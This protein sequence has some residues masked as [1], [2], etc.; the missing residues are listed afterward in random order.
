MNRWFSILHSL[1]AQ[2]ILGFVALTLLTAAAAGIPALWLLH[3][4]LQTQASNQVEQGRLAA[5]SLYDAMQSELASLAT[6]T[7][8]RPT[9]RQLLTQEDWP[10][11]SGYLETLQQGSGLDSVLVCSADQQVAAQA[12]QAPSADLCASLAKPG[13][14]ASSTNTDAQ[15]WL[16]ASHL[17]ADE[18]NKALGSIY[19]G[20]RLD[21]DFAAQMRDQTGLE[22]SLLVA[23]HPAATS[24]QTRLDRPSP[25][26]DQDP[27]QQLKVQDRSYYVGSFPLTADGLQAEVALEVTKLAK[28]ERD[29]AWTLGASILAVA[30]LASLAGILL[31]RR[32]GSPLALLAT[33]AG[34]MS[35]GDLDTPLALEAHVREVALVAQALE[36]ARVDLKRS[37][38]ELRQEKDWTDNLLEAIVEGIVTLDRQGHITF[39]SPGAERITGWKRE[40]VLGRSC[41]EIFR[42]SETSD[43]FSEL[44]PPP[45]R[46]QKIP[47]EL[48]DGRQAVLAVTGARLLPPT[49]GDDRVALVFRDVSEEEAIHRLLGH[50]LANVAHEFRTPLSALAASVE[51]LIDQSPDLSPAELE[52]LLL[53]LHLGTLGLQTLVDNLLESASIE[54]GHFRVHPRP[55]NLTDIIANA[56][57]MMQ[58]LLDKHGQRLALELPVVI[59]TVKADPRRTEQVLINLLSNASKYGPDDAEIEVRATLQGQ[60]VKVIVA[61]SGPGISPEQRKNLFDRFVYSRSGNGKAQVGAGLGLSVVK[62]VVEAHGAEVGIDECPG[63]G[64]AF[65]FTLPLADAGQATEVKI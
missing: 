2:L 25:V 36:G 3:D 31:A 64:S 45:G 1:S 47:M 11:L 42:S 29:L 30:V 17:L 21:D 24:M 46:R 51:L 19:V 57:S 13:F 14:F 56:I 37:L 39:F 49:R 61:D 34:A 50:F 5:Q 10:G 55:S 18:T 65:W 28:T 27:L 16:V 6:L 20:L 4:Q 8:Q 52:E 32:I 59:P 35:E 38:T 44:I 63:G 26:L 7:A 40:Q 48:R 43:S 62:A 22:H 53:S 58:P 54:S 12:G 41:D 15:V 23:G 33:A 9:L 60:W